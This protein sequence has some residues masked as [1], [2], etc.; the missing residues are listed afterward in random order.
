[1]KPNL[2]ALR[3]LQRASEKIAAL[4]NKNPM[5]SPEPS[6]KY[7]GS[8]GSGDKKLKSNVVFAEKNVKKLDETV[9]ENASAL[10]KYR[11]RISVPAQWV[12]EQGIRINNLPMIPPEKIQDL[13]L[14]I[15]RNI[16]RIDGGN[17]SNNI[18]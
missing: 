8:S 17:I 12:P 9:V 16:N 11:T 13:D 15:T 18:L 5:P 7:L 3:A 10:I 2:S 6:K 14:Y 4:E 1:M